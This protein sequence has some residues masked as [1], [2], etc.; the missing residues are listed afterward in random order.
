[1]TQEQVELLKTIADTTRL[2]V[3]GMLA[4]GPRSGRELAEALDVTAPTISHHMK[5]LESV[6]IVT[7]TPEGTR[8]I[9]RLNSALLAAVSGEREAPPIH[10]AYADKIVR[11]FFDGR[12]LKSIPAKR[13]ARVAVLL[14]LLRRF[15]P[16]RDYTEPE[17]NAILRE[18]H[19]DIAT[20]RRELIDYRYLTRQGGVYRVADAPI[21]R[22]ANERQEVPAD[23]A[24]WLSTLIATTVTASG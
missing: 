18:A 20:L 1:M 19:D 11:T 15:T 4:T 12:R 3:L 14:E 7:V 5:R 9:Y 17:V 24:R 2:R 8:R 21:I 22:D 13:R 16:G 6:G 23:E 10:D